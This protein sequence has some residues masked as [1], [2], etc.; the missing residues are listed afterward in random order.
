MRKRLLLLILS[1]IVQYTAYSQGTVR[2]KITDSNGETLIGVTVYLK[3]NMAVGTTTDFDGNYSL[4]IKDPNANILVVSYISYQTI[5]VPVHPQKGEVVIKDFT[6]VTAA[7]EITKAAEVTAKAVK[8]KDYYL[9]NIKQKSATS[10][11]FVSS[12]AMKRTGDNNVTAGV[13]RVSGVSTNGGGFITVR[14][15]GDRYVKT[16]VNGMRIP[17]LDP[18]TN[19]FKLDI[20]PASLVDYVLLTKTASPDL[21]SD[22][23]GAYISVDTKDYPDKLTINAETTFGYNTQSTFNDAVSTQRSGTDWLGYDN[24]LRDQDHSSYVSANVAPSQ[25]QEFVALGLGNYYNEMGVTSTTPW[26]ESYYKLGLMQLGLLPPALFNDPTAVANAKNLYLSG[27]YRSQAFNVINANVPAS[28]KSFPDNW[29][30]TTRQVPLNFSQTFSIGNQV[31]LFGKP[32]GFFAGF[33]YGNSTLYDPNSTANRAAVAADANGNLIRA[34]SSSLTQ[35]SSVELNGWNALF[36]VAYKWNPNNSIAFMFMP[37]VVG[38]NRARNSLDDLDPNQ[39]VI[40]KTQ[41]YEQRKQMIYQMKMENYQPVS[42]VKTELNL[43]YTKGSSSAPDFKNLQYWHDPNSDAYQIGGTIGDGIHRYYRYL[44]DNLFD[45]KLSA[46]VP[47]SDKPGLSRKLKFGGAYQYNARTSDQYD[48]DVIIGPY[49]G[50]M[51]TD[52]VDA[53]L[54]LENFDISS[55]VDNFGYTYSTLNAHY[56]LDNSP[57]NYTF[58]NSQ[59]IAGYAMADYAINNRLRF[60]GGLRIEYADI[61]TDVVAFDSAGYAP[62][63]P[64]RSYS[65]SYPL[66]NPGTL[67]ETSFLPSINAIYKL[68][69]D[70]DAPVNLRANYSKTVARPSMRELSD[71]AQFDY[72]YRAFVFGNSDLQIVQINNFD[73]RLEYYGK[74]KDSYSVSLFYKHFKN[75]IELVNSGGFT[76]QNVDNSNVQGIEFEG[77]KRVIK[78]L[79][80]GANLTFVRSNTE[81]VRTRL[82][83]ADGVKTYIPLDTVSRPMFGQAPYIFNIIVGYTLDSI[84]L[85]IALSYNVQG[86]RLVIAADV[87]EI[88]DVYELPRN[89]LDFKVTKTLG[90]HFALGLNIKNILNAPIQR[91]YK[92]DDGYSLDFDK[93]VIGSTFEL[94]LAYKL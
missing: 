73:L 74:N 30:T 14:G 55:G 90:K 1:F 59:L 85:S 21:P 40:T 52:D 94:S 9:E 72:E 51:L 42:K 31:K 84:G 54:S 13:A 78:G 66:V 49:K 34:V 39:N 37:N 70:D 28:G 80:I 41:F 50:P 46:E 38:S 12:E 71:V 3:A 63:D 92:Y 22:W 89:L 81:F 16:A 77:K 68:V 64:R 23:A 62:N 29:N 4:T 58:A 43:S 53:Y 2:G 19:N 26:N 82:E 87:Q 17:T 91:S 76:W 10:I 48:Y 65:S 56:G 47:I 88:P 93:F 44:T 86:P 11:D 67:N 25:Y 60:E 8:A 45:S 7:K 20:F 83:I 32:L 5:E 79:N 15:L 27:P 57:A 18:F 33:R 24:S 69:P 75:H 6:M 35:Q 61:L 36:N